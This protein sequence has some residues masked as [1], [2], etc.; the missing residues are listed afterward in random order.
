M[1][2][3]IPKRAGGYSDYILGID[4]GTK[5]CED[6]RKCVSCASSGVDVF[7]CYAAVDGSDDNK[8][9]YSVDKNVCSDLEAVAN[10]DVVKCDLENSSGGLIFRE[11]QNVF[12]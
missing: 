7:D 12:L 10:S 9:E 3:T 2:K 11:K 5:H 1:S 8:D 6:G 4:S